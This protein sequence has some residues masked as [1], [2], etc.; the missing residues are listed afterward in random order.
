M[1]FYSA[2]RD[3]WSLTKDTFKVIGRDRAILKPTIAQIRLSMLFFL[4]LI[5]SGGAFLFTRGGVRIVFLAVFL[6]FLMLIFPLFPFIKMYYRAAQCW[7]VYHVFTGKEVSYKDGLKRARKNKGDIFILGLFDIILTALARKLK[8]GMNSGGAGILLGILRWILGKGV[9]EGWDLIGHFLLPAAI[10]E[11]KNVMQVLPEI[12][13]I[14]KNVPA[15]LGGVFGFDFVGDMVRGYVTLFI[16]VFSLLGMFIGIYMRSWALFIIL[17][18]LLIAVNVII[19]I[20]ID[21]VKT[22][23]FTL[24]Y[25]AVTMPRNLP[26]EYRKGIMHYLLYKE[27]AYKKRGKARKEAGH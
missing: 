16:V 15:V 4:F 2:L 20:F 26:P 14:R 12:K 7:M 23:Y 25:T 17:L 22:I 24:F 10:I 1:G 3:T 8:G 9:E 19:R 13:N 11:D 5:L 21:M 18:L 6:F 27:S